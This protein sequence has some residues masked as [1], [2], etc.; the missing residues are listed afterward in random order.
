MGRSLVMYP[1]GADRIPG[2]NYALST[3]F[4]DDFA[5]RLT[6]CHIIYSIAAVPRAF[7]RV[8][9]Q[10]V[11]DGRRL[12]KRDLCAMRDGDRAVRVAGIGESRI[13]Q[14]E[15]VATMGDP[16][17]VDHG[18]GYPHTETCP[19]RSDLVQHNSPRFAGRIPRIHRLGSGPGQ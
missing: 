4:S 14:E 1:S 10:F 8:G 6:D 17:P 11:V 3:E 18:L 2:E 5:F 12:Q 13:G 16:V 7:Y 9:P 15:K 19:A